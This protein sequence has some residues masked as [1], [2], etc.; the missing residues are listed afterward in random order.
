M[1][2]CQYL[3]SFVKSVFKTNLTSMLAKFLNILAETDLSDIFWKVLINNVHY[4]R[5][6][7]SVNK[8]KKTLYKII[9]KMQ[10]DVFYLQASEFIVWIHVFKKVWSNQSRNKHLISQV[11]TD[12]L[13]NYVS[14]SDTIFKVFKFRKKNS[15]DSLIIVRNA[16][17]NKKIN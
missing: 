16:D 8:H 2:T 5:N 9:F 1:I 17:I 4:T 15:T 12:H 10:S 7:K 14:Q 11:Y 3:S 6:W 13:I